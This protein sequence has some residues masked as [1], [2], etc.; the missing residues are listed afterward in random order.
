[1]RLTHVNIL[2]LA[3]SWNRNEKGNIAMMVSANV[4]WITYI[5]SAG[6]EVKNVDS[7]AASITRTIKPRIFRW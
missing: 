5:Y 2:H 4:T 1:M 6:I 7:I 3:S